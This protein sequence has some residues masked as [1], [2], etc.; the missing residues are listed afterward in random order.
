[1]ERPHPTPA[2]RLLLTI[3]L[4]AG[5]RGTQNLN[6]DLIG[7]PQLNGIAL[8]SDN[9]AKQPADG[10][11]FIAVFQGIDHFLSLFLAALRGQDQQNIKNTHDNE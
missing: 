8:N 6:L 3:W 10:D 4:Q 5:D 1:M 7:D 2:L 9:G 11:H